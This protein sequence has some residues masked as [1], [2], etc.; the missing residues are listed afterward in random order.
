M[1]KQQNDEATP[2]AAVSSCSRGGN[3][4]HEGRTTMYDPAPAPA[5]RATARRVDRGC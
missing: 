2:T 4:E 1:M 3:G 5:L